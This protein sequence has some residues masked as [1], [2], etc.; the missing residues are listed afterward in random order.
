M[1]CNYNPILEHIYIGNL[2]SGRDPEFIKNLDCIVDLSSNYAKHPPYIKY[3]GF[4]VE[5]DPL[6]NIIPTCEK[7]FDFLSENKGKRTLVHCIAGKSRSVAVVV[8]YI[9]RKYGLSFERSYMFVKSKRPVIAM[10]EGFYN[11]LK[12]L[13]FQ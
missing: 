8:Y 2:F 11:Q 7:V 1:N 13:K 5:D 9:M 3:V 4:D 10:N 6:I 12:S